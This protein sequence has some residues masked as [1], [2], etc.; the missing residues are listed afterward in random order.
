MEATKF[1]LLVLGGN[2]SQGLIEGQCGYTSTPEPEDTG[3]Q[4]CYECVD[5]SDN[6]YWCDGVCHSVTNENPPQNYCS[7]ETAIFSS[8]RA[9]CASASPGPGTAEPGQTSTCRLGSLTLS[10]VK[11]YVSD[12]EIS[13]DYKLV[14]YD[15]N[16]DCDWNYVWPRGFP[17]A[18]Y[19]RY[20]YYGTA[21][22]KKTWSGNIVNGD[23]ILPYPNKNNDHTRTIEN[24]YSFTY[25]Y[26][27]GYDA[28]CGFEVT[29]G[30]SGGDSETVF[31][32]FPTHCVC[33]LAD[34][35]NDDWKC[36]GQNYYTCNSLGQWENQGLVDKQCGYTLPT[37]VKVP[38]D[39]TTCATCINEPGTDFSW[40][41]PDSNN[42]S[43]GTCIY[44]SASCSPSYWQELT[45]SSLCA[46][47]TP[48]CQGKECGSDGCG[49]SCGTCPSGQS[50][51]T[52]GTCV[53]TSTT[54]TYHSDCPSDGFKDGGEYCGTYGDVMDEYEDWS[55]SGGKCVVSKSNKVKVDC[56]TGE[57]CDS[58]TLTCVST[59]AQ[60]GMPNIVILVK[61]VLGQ[62][63]IGSLIMLLVLIMLL[64]DL[65]ILLVVVV[66]LQLL[67]VLRR[68]KQLVKLWKIGLAQLIA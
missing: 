58:S 3:S 23:V 18:A 33:G 12:D 8:N 32:S 13:F 17:Y 10:N 20:Q 66:T 25:D 50:C 68:K 27:N 31:Y 57:T 22:Q 7:S 36:E 52:I 9:A 63:I 49:G 40:C 46:G 61:L 19:I 56:L 38:S 54:C 1:I 51:S 39:Y 30:F 62:D 59:T 4:D 53:S 2:I 15:M 37:P 47:C 41:T 67:F 44:T 11:H 48:N 14:A 35:A 42:P 21:T 5:A 34:V 60:M 6:Y 24:D 55:C 45:S 28:V 29:M 26:P 65:Q 43:T 16:D 64:L